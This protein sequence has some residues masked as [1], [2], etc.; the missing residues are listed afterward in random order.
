MSYCL[1]F[2]FFLNMYKIIFL[3]FDRDIMV[4]I[5]MVKFWF[6]FNIQFKINLHAQC[7]IFLISM[8]TDYFV[9]YR[10]NFA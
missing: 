3:E 10:N 7:L 8:C 4:L 5:S 9:H 6:L 2:L 1:F